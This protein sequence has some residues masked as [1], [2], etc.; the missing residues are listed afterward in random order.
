MW[1][2]N[3][4]R[5]G[6]ELSRLRL[7]RQYTFT[8]LNVYL[9]NFYVICQCNFLRKFPHWRCTCTKKCT[10]N[11]KYFHIV[12][13]SLKIDFQLSVKKRF[14]RTLEIQKKLNATNVNK[15]TKRKNWRRIIGITLVHRLFRVVLQTQK[16]V[17]S[18]PPDLSWKLKPCSAS[19]VSFMGKWPK[20]LPRRLVSSIPSQVPYLKMKTRFCQKC[21]RTEQTIR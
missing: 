16:A 19:W 17:G 1:N 5:Q 21:D 8:V 6:K 18:N 11:V 14:D 2:L 3:W 4:R 20:Q 13:T 9:R 15:W 10:Y 12:S 7:Y